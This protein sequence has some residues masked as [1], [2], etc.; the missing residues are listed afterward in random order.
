MYTDTAK[1]GR[2]K[3]KGA[4]LEFVGE[5]HSKL[6]LYLSKTIDE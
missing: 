5:V 6:P 1:D 2:C 4:L 3:G